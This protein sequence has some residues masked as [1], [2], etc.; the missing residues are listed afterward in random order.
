MHYS[1]DDTWD[2]GCDYTCVCEDAQNGRYQ[3]TEKS[4]HAVVLHCRQLYSI[5]MDCS[6]LSRIRTVSVLVN[7][8]AAGEFCGMFDGT[9]PGRAGTLGGPHF[10]QPHFS[11][12]LPVTWGDNIGMLKCDWSCKG[13][14]FSVTG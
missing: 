12:S 11:E 14:H 5:M 4:V 7:L 10:P 9:S 2:D 8:V 3:C 13:F 6:V 1:Q